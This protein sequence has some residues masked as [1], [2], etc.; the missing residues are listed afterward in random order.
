M[1][2]SQITSQLTRVTVPSIGNSNF[3]EGIRNAFETINNNF[4]TIASLPFIQGV[5]GDSYT[6]ISKDIWTEVNNNITPVY[7]ALTKEGSVLLNSIFESV[8]DD[9]KKFHEGDSFD[10]C[11]TNKLSDLSLNGVSPIDSFFIEENGNVKLVNN[12]LYFYSVIN[13][14]NEEQDTYLGQYFYFIDYRISELGNAYQDKKLSD[15]NDFTGFYQ[16]QPANENEPEKYNAISIVP[17]LYYD[18]DKDDI[19]W[20]YNGQQTGISAIGPKGLDGKDANFKIVYV[21]YTD[22]TENSGDILGYFDSAKGDIEYTDTLE[23]CFCLVQ[24]VNTETN[25]DNTVTITSYVDSAFGEVHNDKVYWE[26]SLKMGNLFNNQNITKYFCNMG[27]TST[28]I[29]NHPYYFAIPAYLDRSDA[30]TD[31][32]KVGHVFM[33]STEGNLILQKADNAFT[34]AGGQTPLYDLETESTQNLFDIKNYDINVDQNLTIDGTIGVSG[35]ASFNS[36]LSVGGTLGV[37]GTGTFNSDLSVGGTLGVSG[38]GT[39]NSDLSVGGTLGVSGT[40]T[41]NSD[42]TVGGTLGVSGTGTFNSDLTVDGMLGVSGTG[43]FNSDLSVGGTLGVSGTG[44]FNSDLSVGGTLGVSGTGTFNSDLSV[45]GTLGVTGSATIENGAT[46]RNGATISGMETLSG[47]VGLS[48]TGGIGVTGTNGG[49]GV[50]I[51]GGNSRENDGG[52]GLVVRGGTSLNGSGKTGLGLI[53]ETGGAEI[54]NDL[55]ISGTLGVSGTG[56]FNS[57]LTVV[58]SLGVTG[59]GTFGSNLTVAG[60][61][62]VTGTGTFGSNL[63]V[64]GSLG[65]TGTGTFNSNLT[66]VGSLGVTGNATIDEVQIID[67]KVKAPNG[68]FQTSDETLKDFHNDIQVDFEKLSLIPKKQFTWKSDEVKH[69]EIGTSAQEVRKLYPELVSE[70]ENGILSVAYDKLS[71]VALKAIDELYKKNQELERRIKEL[72]NKL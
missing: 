3:A 61:L 30:N 26:N 67:G 55:S 45:G 57:D 18:K 24:F 11:K 69:M 31:N 27:N 35:A 56:T 7:Y 41:F 62:G 36:D 14:L 52:V 22:D 2:N 68:F 37:S 21:K 5:Q 72:E 47:G 39:F 46:I 51:D 54:Y 23:N 48:V 25:E 19:C 28:S 33:G 49:T 13:N 70:N 10:E 1:S 40:G 16:Y 42:L 71:I 50:S 53:V 12:K 6:L 60:S 29:E 32:Y 44:T 17:N 20:K 38:T 63:T 34:E 58:G 9:T 8:L 59:T 65:V 4:K 64:A 43:T 66:V 15:F